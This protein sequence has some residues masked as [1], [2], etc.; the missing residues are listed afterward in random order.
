VVFV[1]I[2]GALII[3]CMARFGSEPAIPAEPLSPVII[4]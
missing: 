1:P 4:G 3:G 2:V